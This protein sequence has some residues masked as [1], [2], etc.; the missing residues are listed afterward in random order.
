MRVFVTGATG[1]IGSRVVS[2]L[3]GAGH[4]VLG[5]TRSDA[6]AESLR[7]AGA[8]VHRGSLEDVESL[9][10]GAANANG[11]I[12]L[13]FDHSAFNEGFS[14]FIEACEQDK[15]AIEAM[16]GVLAGSNRPLIVTSGTGLGSPAPG[17]PA[18]EDHLDTAHPNP[19]TG[20][21]VL[22]ASLVESGV[23]LSVVRLPQ[24]H[25]TV[26]QGLVTY[27][28]LIARQKGVSAY[29]GNGRNRWPAAHVTD[30]ARLYRLA[31]EK[32]QP[33]ARYHAVAEEGI[34]NREIAE[35]IGK[36]LKVPV[37]SIT[38]EESQ[39]HFGWLAMFA[40]A[41][42]PASSAKTC[43][44][45]GWNPKGPGMIADLENMQYARP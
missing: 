13:A 35:T 33:G 41:D 3:I 28:I 37:V 25:D 42:L 18:I 40:G 15:R 24:V 14:K 17:Q 44:V 6:G 16:A 27:S 10:T 8:E 38:P 11:V 36:G 43:E 22:C 2:E 5:L 20:S 39:A 30:V 4:A 32:A 23:N 45:L 12:H 19:R 9:R 7:A 21:E 31:I 1:F 29:I 34:T 26:K